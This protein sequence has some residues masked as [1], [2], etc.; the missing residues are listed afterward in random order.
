MQS[1]PNITTKVNAS[2][3]FWDSASFFGLRK[4]LKT[5]LITVADTKADPWLSTL[6]LA[7][8]AAWERLFGS[9]VRWQSVASPFEVYADGIDL[10]VSPIY[11][12]ASI[13]PDNDLE[14]MDLYQLDGF[15][16]SSKPIP[17]I[18]TKD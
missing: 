13:D 1:A 12:L 2:Y 4:P 6:I 16:W 18:E 15:P 3:F 14:P 7:L 5:T 10:V 8:S 17:S 9:N 11:V